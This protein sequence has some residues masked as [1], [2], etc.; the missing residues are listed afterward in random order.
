VEPEIVTILLFA[1]P[2]GVDMMFSEKL[3][4]LCGA[5]TVPAMANVPA[6]VLA[7]IQTDAAFEMLMRV[8]VNICPF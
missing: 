4:P 6:V 8:P 1:D 2:V 5:C 3:D 7:G